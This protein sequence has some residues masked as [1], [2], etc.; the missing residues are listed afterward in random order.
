[1]ENTCEISGQEMENK[2]KQLEDEWRIS[3][4]HMGNA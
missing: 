2:W 4:K 1:M 3:G